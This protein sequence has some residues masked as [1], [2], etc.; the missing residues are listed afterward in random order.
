VGDRV[1]TYGGIAEYV[2]AKAVNNHRLRIMKETDSWQNAL[3]YDPMQYAFGGVRDANVRPGDEVMIFGL[4]AIGLLAVELCVSIGATV[5]AAD[6]L[7]NRRDIALSIGAKRVY[8]PTKEDVGLLV[9]ECSLHGGADSAIDTSGSP[10]ALQQALRGLAYGGVVSYVA[11]AK[12]FKGGLDFGKEAHFNN[13]SIIFSRAANEPNKDAPRWNRKRIEDGC[14]TMLM[15]ETVHCES[16]ITPIVPFSKSAEAY[17]KYVD[18]EQ[19]LSIKL[20][21]TFLEE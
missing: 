5:Y 1:T 14:F 13:L 18:Q 19:H 20:G 3:C 2:V 7:A 21:I 12:E 17:M 6:P 9:K 10:Y 8:D 16:I 11:F 15:N 4:G